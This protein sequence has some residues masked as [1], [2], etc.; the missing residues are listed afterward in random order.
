MSILKKIV[1]ENTIKIFVMNIYFFFFIKRFCKAIN[2]VQQNIFPVKF[3]H[4]ALN[5]F[6][7]I[8]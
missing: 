5:L 8:K 2:L 3:S 1:K 6:K 4:D 7:E